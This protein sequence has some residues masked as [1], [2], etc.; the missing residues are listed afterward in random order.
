MTIKSLKIKT[1]ILHFSDTSLY[2]N[3]KYDFHFNNWEIDLYTREVLIHK[4]LRQIDFFNT[5]STIR[6]V[7]AVRKSTFN[8]EFTCIIEFSN[9]Y[10]KVGS[11]TYLKTKTLS[12]SSF[13]DIKNENYDNLN[14]NNMTCY[15]TNDGMD[16][17]I[18]KIYK[19]DSDSVRIVTGTTKYLIN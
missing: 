3:N 8:F 7:C 10:E 6:Y 19:T 14:Y 9:Y 4:I 11:D 18:Q 15:Y 13:K 5:S 1:H 16:A 2:N 17:Y 12:L